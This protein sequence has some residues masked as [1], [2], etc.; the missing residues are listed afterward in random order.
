MGARSTA[1]EVDSQGQVTQQGQI[2]KLYLV[3]DLG[4]AF[5]VASTTELWPG[6]ASPPR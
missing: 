3:N 2:T 5:P 6:S 1:G 4:V